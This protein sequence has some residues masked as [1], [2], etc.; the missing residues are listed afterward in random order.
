MIR[1]KSGLLAAAAVVALGVGSLTSCDRQ[2]ASAPAAA[3]STSEQTAPAAAADLVIRNARIYTQNPQ[4]PE[5]ESVAVRD[6]A[7]VAVGDDATTA[8]LV[9][10][11][12]QVIDA[13]QG[14]L[15]PGLHDA[16]VHPLSS[17]AAL[18]GCALSDAVSEEAILQRLQDCAEDGEGW[19]VGLDFNLGLFPDGNPHK[20]SLDALFP[21]RP[22]YLAA[23]DGHSAWVN[24]SALALAGI[25]GDTPN[26]PQGVI[27]RDPATGEATGTLRETAQALVSDLLPETTPEDDVAALRAALQFMHSKGITSFIDAAVGEQHWRAYRAL[28]TAGELQARVRTSLTHGTFSQHTGEEF[29]TVLARRGEYAS[30]HVNTDAVKLFVDGVLEGE[31][32]A[33]VTPYLGDDPHSGEINFDPEE[34]KDIITR[35]DAMG[36]Q[37]HVH[38]I[39]DLGVRTALDAFEAARE[40]NGARD[41]RHHIA[42]LQLVHPDDIPRF[43]ELNVSTTF[44][45]LWA[46]PDSYIT[47]INFPAVGAERVERMYP[48]RSL[49][50]AGARIV[51]GS[52][53]SVSSVNPL[54]A[55]ETALRRQDPDDLVQGT[56]NAQEAV[57]LDTMLAAYT[58]DAA[59]LMHQEDSVGSIE[60]G[61]RA[62]LVLLSQDLYRIPA[63]DI[64]TTT[65]QM[66]LFDGEV[67]YQAR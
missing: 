3:A 38:A 29:E 57:T 33:L 24:S 2:Q 16:H 64:N 58:R 5:A 10:D 22:V 14:M 18:L 31:T 50:R 11:D 23:A 46:W 8:G 56:L 15:L 20:A 34:L 45:A 28:E 54:D 49:Q 51:G 1:T 19:L 60:V 36:L 37:V 43:A 61:K 7:I 39:G 17:G 6:G 62:D 21:E 47:E 13:E 42:H 40:R 25:T 63:E 55:I 48:V 32:A 4:Q 53:W 27:E 41:N 30:E 67:V 65:V 59:W 66:T 26:P 44:Q 35:F 12:T 52:D 9:D